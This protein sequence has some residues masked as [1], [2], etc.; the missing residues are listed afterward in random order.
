MAV[1]LMAIE[2]LQRW[3]KNNS[4]TSFKKEKISENDGAVYKDSGQ[5]QVNE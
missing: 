4:E 3:E 1:H 5:N 2:I